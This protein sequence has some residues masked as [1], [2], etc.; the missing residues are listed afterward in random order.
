MQRRRLAPL[1]RQRQGQE[2]VDRIGGFGPEP[3]D[4]RPPAAILA[5][6]QRIKGERRE[7][8]RPRL[9]SVEPARGVRRLRLRPRACESLGERTAPSRRNFHKRVVVKTHERRLERAG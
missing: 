7:R 4:Q 5:E 9:P 6:Q 1:M 8:L 3:A 2:F